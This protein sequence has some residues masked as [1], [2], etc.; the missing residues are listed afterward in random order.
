MLGV[1]AG[2]RLTRRLRA[3]VDYDTSFNADKTVHVISGAVDY[4][5]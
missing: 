2:I 4:R 3:F 5:W 1:G